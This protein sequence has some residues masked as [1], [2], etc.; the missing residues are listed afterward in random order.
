M[1]EMPFLK[2]LTSTRA[3][4]IRYV[5]MPPLLLDEVGEDRLNDLWL[6]GG[7]RAMPL[8]AVMEQLRRL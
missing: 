1:G 3:G 6:R 8:A 7:L 2:P 5:E 4:R